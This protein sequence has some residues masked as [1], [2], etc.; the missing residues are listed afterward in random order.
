VGTRLAVSVPDP[1]SA[2]ST[3]VAVDE[4]TVKINGDRW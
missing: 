1:P 2:Q 3:R 4:T